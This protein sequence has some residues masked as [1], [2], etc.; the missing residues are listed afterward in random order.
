MINQKK[1][2]FRHDPLLTADFSLRS[3]VL[4]LRSQLCAF[5]FKKVNE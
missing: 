4:S 5:A 2:A 3:L 1:S